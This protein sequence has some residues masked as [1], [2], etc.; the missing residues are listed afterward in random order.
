MA[1]LRFVGLN[2]KGDPSAWPGIFLQFGSAAQK[3]CGVPGSWAQT[4]G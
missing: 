4:Q 3:E 2:L 1:R